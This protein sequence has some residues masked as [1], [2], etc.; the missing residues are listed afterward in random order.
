MRENY[1]SDQMKIFL[2]VFNNIDFFFLKKKKKKI[3]LKFVLHSFISPLA[4]NSIWEPVCLTLNKGYFPGVFKP[5]NN[6]LL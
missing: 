2:S 5:M 6:V 3:D 4:Q 1:S